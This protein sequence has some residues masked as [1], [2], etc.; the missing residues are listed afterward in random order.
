MTGA[1]ETPAWRA[2]LAL[3]TL[4]HNACILLSEVTGQWYV[5]A[6]IEVT[7][8]GLLRSVCEHRDSPERA[9]LAFLAELTELPIDVLIVAK[10][11]GQ[12]RH[13]RWNGAA[14][15]EQY[16]QRLEPGS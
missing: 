5:S 14:F 13:Y 8:G 10:P 9:V 4:D 12:R 2:M 16:D 11:T 1:Y 6:R 7:D 3:K 15:S